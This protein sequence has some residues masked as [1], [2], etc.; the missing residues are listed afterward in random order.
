MKSSSLLVYIAADGTYLNS[1]GDRPGHFFNL[2]PR[3]TRMRPYHVK[4]FHDRLGAFHNV[5]IQKVAIPYPFKS[6]CSGP[7]ITVQNLSETF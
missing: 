2:K 6:M 5:P 1:M 3:A 4:S 7:Y